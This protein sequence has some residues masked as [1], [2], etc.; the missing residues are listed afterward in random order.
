MIFLGS[1]WLIEGR[2]FHHQI[3]GRQ[4]R[5]S[6]LLELTNCQDSVGKNICTQKI[7]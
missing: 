2:Y 5:V 7:F 1:S 4:L 6:F 3:H